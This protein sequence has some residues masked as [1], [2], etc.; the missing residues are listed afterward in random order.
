MC[1]APPGAR[2]TPG[3]RRRTTLRHCW[4]AAAGTVRTRNQTAQ[5]AV[6]RGARA[7]SRAC[8]VRSCRTTRVRAASRR[9]LTRMWARVLKGA[10]PQGRRRCRARRPSGRTACRRA[11][12]PARATRARTRAT[13]GTRRRSAGW[14]GRRMT[15][16]ACTRS[17][18]P[19]G[20]VRVSAPR[21][22]AQPG[23]DASFETGTTRTRSRRAR[24]MRR[25]WASSRWTK[26]A[27]CATT[28][29]RAACTFS[30]TVWTTAKR[31]GS[32]ASCARH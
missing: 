21:H 17:R 14:T 9:D 23:A 20:Q 12:A 1:R 27:R 5:R 31:A 15:G 10:D 26:I 16:T 3:A 8:R 4:A 13:T 2:T 6:A 25:R 7:A 22:T 28:A 19:M 24:T 18:G 32:G 11:S 29:R 30:R